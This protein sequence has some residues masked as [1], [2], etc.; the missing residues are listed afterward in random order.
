[1]LVVLR[2][3]RCV[4]I[5]SAA[6]PFVFREKMTG[7]LCYRPAVIFPALPGHILFLLRVVRCLFCFLS[8]AHPRIRH[9]SF[10]LSV[11][12]GPPNKTNFWCP[13]ANS[14]LQVSFQCLDNYCFFFLLVW[15]LLTIL[16]SP[17][18]T[19]TKKVVQDLPISFII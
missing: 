4:A 7:E 2:S 12:H 5:K 14:P 16:T 9:E 8:D 3:A 17:K 15:S 13:K 1:M 11:M 10:F 6:P 18:K 19:L